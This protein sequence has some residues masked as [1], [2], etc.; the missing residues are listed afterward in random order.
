MIPIRVSVEFNVEPTRTEK[1]IAELPAR[2]RNM[3]PLMEHGIAPATNRMLR[4]HWESKGAAFRQKWAPLEWETIRKR[5]RHGTLSK[6]ILRDTDHLFR[7][8]FRAAGAARIMS[9]SDGV[10]LAVSVKEAKAALHQVGTQ[11]MPERPVIPDPLPTTFRREVTQMVRQYL[12][13]GNVS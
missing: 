11:F 6:G 9:L 1:R 7:A 12:R 5:E 10:R 2:L 8:V 4:R 13:T 3:R